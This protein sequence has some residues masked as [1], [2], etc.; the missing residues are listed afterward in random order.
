MSSLQQLALHLVPT[1]QVLERNLLHLIGFH[2]RFIQDFLN[3]QVEPM[4]EYFFS[5]LLDTGNTSLFWMM[6]FIN[7]QIHR[8]P[9]NVAMLAC[10]QEYYRANQSLVAF[11]MRTHWDKVVLFVYTMP[12]REKNTMTKN[13]FQQKKSFQWTKEDWDFVSTLIFNRHFYISSR[14]IR[15]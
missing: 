4:D 7:R 12:S 9:F 15:K 5:A 11:A 2:N 13:I 6:K 14:Y 8:L 3:Y 10:W 1:E